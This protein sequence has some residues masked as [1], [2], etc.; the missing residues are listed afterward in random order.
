MRCVIPRCVILGCLV[1]A[2]WTCALFAQALSAQNQGEAKLLCVSN[3]SGNADIFLMNA[4]GTGAV[5]L[6]QSAGD[7]T[8]PAWAPD[9]KKIA[10]TS[11][12]DG[13]PQIYL[14]D[15]DGTSVRRLTDSESSDRAPAWSPDGKKIAFCRTANGNAEVFVMNGD[16]SN[17][18]NVTDHDA[19]DGDPAW[20]PDGKLIAFASNRGG[21]GFRLFVMDHDGKNAQ[22]VSEANNPFGYV[23]PAW[24]PDGKAIAFTDLGKNA[25]EVFVRDH[26]SGKHTPLTK[27][28]GLNTQLAWAP[29]GK[30]AAFLH[31][32]IADYMDKV[33][34]LYVIDADGKNAK[35][36]LKREVP[37]EGGRPAW[38]PK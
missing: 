3:R 4:D 29:G 22:Q 30:Q 11:E 21:Q 33:T 25:L 19:F 17:P 37:L 1:L 31:L 27:L 26:A 35:E 16:G 13:R 6:T 15:A 23:Y 38:K 14:M 36:I 7:D 24:S 10:F 8:L 12:R 18:I 9:G 34:S 2:A 32:D 5:N 28:G 20:S